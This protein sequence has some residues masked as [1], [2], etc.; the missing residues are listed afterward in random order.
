MISV[1]I[2]AFKP[3][4]DAGMSGRIPG[5]QRTAAQERTFPHGMPAHPAGWRSGRP[6]RQT[7]DA[8]RNVP[9]DPATPT[10]IPRRTLVALDQPVLHLPA[11][12]RLRPATAHLHVA[13]QRPIGFLRREL[14][15]I[16]DLRGKEG[17]EAADDAR[18]AQAIP[19]ARRPLL[20]PGHDGWNDPWRAD[21]R[22]SASWC[23]WSVRWLVREGSSAAAWEHPCGRTDRVTS[24]A[25]PPATRDADRAPSAVSRAQPVVWPCRSRTWRTH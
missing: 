13:R 9:S 11:H 22:C 25:P 2:Y 20:L 18:R 19:P 15:G 1:W 4:R 8:A 3:W 7:Y 14:A 6:A 23:S 16:V 21:R 5:E 17:V 24:P 10:R 12:V